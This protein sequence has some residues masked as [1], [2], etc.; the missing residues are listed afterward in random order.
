MNLLHMRIHSP[1]TIITL[2]SFF[3]WIAYQSQPN[4][5][6]FLGMYQNTWDSLF[7][8]LYR[9]ATYSFLHAGFFHFFGNVIFIYYFGRIIENI[10]GANWVWNLWLFITIFS[11]WILYLFSRYPTIGWSCFTLA[12]LSIFT[13]NLYKKWMKEDFK[14]AVLLIVLN[15][16]LWLFWNVSFLWHLSGAIGGLL[17]VWVSDKYAKRIR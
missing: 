5:V 10:Y 13:Y 17:F 12:L 6:S 2:F 4:I 3:W 8:I 7:Q 1:I 9:F 16:F 11:G 15:I 14:W